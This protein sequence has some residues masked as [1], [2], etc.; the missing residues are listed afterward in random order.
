MKMRPAEDKLFVNPLFEADE[1]DPSESSKKKQPKTKKSTSF[2]LNK[3]NFP[4]ASYLCFLE[5]PGGSKEGAWEP[6]ASWR[7]ISVP[8][9]STPKSAVVISSQP[10]DLPKGRWVPPA[11]W[12]APDDLRDNESL[13]VGLLPSF[14][15]FHPSFLE[16]NQFLLDFCSGTFVLPS[17]TQPSP[18]S[19]ARRTSRLVN[20][21]SSS[22]RSFSFVVMTA[23]SSI[24][25][26]TDM[27]RLPFHQ[28][29][30]K[31]AAQQAR[32]FYDDYYFIY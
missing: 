10:E 11:S 27:V 8:E 24:F 20:C 3:Q 5:S 6:P 4:S 1:V 2:F 29:I 25:R 14:C 21:A 16:I 28:K 22:A 32:H 26:R 23:T 7:V 30:R 18:L 12:N 9:P 31:E 13:D 17:V 19:P 15:F